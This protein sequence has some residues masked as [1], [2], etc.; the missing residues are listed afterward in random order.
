LINM[1]V[2]SSS[3]VL[4]MVQSGRCNLGLAMVPVQATGHGNIEII[5]SANMVV[6]IPGGH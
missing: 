5:V 6:V 1:H 2:H 3:N 4:D